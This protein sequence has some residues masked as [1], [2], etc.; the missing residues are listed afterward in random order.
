MPTV[1]VAVYRTLENTEEVRRALAAAGVPHGDIRIS[2]YVDP[3][4]RNAPASIERESGF[5]YLLG[6][7]PEV[8]IEAYRQGIARGRTIVAVRSADD[9]ADRVE[10]VLARFEPIDIGEPDAIPAAE[11][12]LAEETGA[13]PRR[14]AGEAPAKPRLRRYAVPDRA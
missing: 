5:L 1:L 11:R 13:L 6:G 3:V 2:E 7:I 9:L 14:G 12:A 4:V 8:D 10:S